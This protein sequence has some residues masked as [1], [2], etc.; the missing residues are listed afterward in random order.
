MASAPK[1]GN[2]SRRRGVRITM[3]EESRTLMLADLGAADDLASRKATGLVVSNFITE[4]TFGADSMAIIWWLAGRKAG[5]R[6]SFTRVLD[7]FPSMA[8]LGE[9]LEDGTFKIESIEDEP[10]DEEHPLPSAAV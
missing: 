9:M 4:E 10:E 8:T 5:L 2:R 3:G 6:I 7:V 1:P